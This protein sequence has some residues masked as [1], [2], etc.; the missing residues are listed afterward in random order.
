[1]S[2]VDGIRIRLDGMDADDLTL[3]L[4]AVDPSPALRPRPGA[5]SPRLAPTDWLSDVFVFDALPEVVSIADEF[6]D[7]LRLTPA[8]PWT[9]ARPDF[10]KVVKRSRAARRDLYRLH[11]VLDIPAPPLVV[12]ETTHP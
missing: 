11:E 7:R 9:G 8:E 10:A 4:V 2:T 3:L 5:E 12:D 6:L 1:A